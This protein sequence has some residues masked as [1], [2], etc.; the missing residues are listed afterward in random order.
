MARAAE[1][2]PEFP[3]V[4]DSGAV[5]ALA[6]GD[7]SVRRYLDITADAEL[8]IFVS[9][10][11]VAETVRRR[12]PRDASVNRVLNE[13]DAVPPV[14]EQTGR[15]AGELL[16]RAESGATIDALVVAQTVELGGARIL[17]SDPGDIQA[18]AGGEA[19]ILVF[20]I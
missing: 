20:G 9:P 5:I 15:I 2:V 19:D 1:T 7:A 4:L 12:G 17:T 16:G 3:L 6:R 13:V 8:E 18:L 14:T 11:V 10:V